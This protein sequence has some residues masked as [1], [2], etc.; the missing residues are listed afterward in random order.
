[1]TSLFRELVSVPTE[2]CFSIRTVEASS[3]ACSFWAIA[4]PTTPPPITACVKSAFRDG[5]V[6]NGLERTWRVIDGETT[7]DENMAGA[8]RWNYRMRTKIDRKERYAR[9]IALTIPTILVLI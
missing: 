8:R 9:Q 3:L 1:M 5:V 6:E 4:R 7:R 2:P